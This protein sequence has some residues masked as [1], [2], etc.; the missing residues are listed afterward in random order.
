MFLVCRGLI[1]FR[2]KLELET[3]LEEIRVLREQL[4]AAENDHNR[5]RAICA[6]HAVRID[7]AGPVSNDQDNS[8]LRQVL[9]EI[10][11]NSVLLGDM[12]SNRCDQEMARTRSTDTCLQ[13]E[14]L[15]LQR[16]Q[17]DLAEIVEHI[18]SSNTLREQY[19]SQLTDDFNVLT[20]L[21]LSIDALQREL[22]LEKRS[23]NQKDRKQLPS[24]V[25]PP[26]LS[27]SADR[28]ADLRAQLAALENTY[29]QEH[30]CLQ[31]QLSR[32][33]LNKSSAKSKFQ[34]DIKSLFTDLNF[35]RERLAKT[36]NGLETVNKH[37]T[38]D[39]E[40]L[41][42]IVAPLVDN[43]DGLREKI[44]HLENDIDGYF[45]GHEE[46]QVDD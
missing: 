21:Y 8:E 23:Q 44:N 29:S 35:I 46:S 5:W 28:V 2:L 17:K 42:H 39:E 33:K 20:D 4:S 30:A 22:D 45:Y 10:S 37:Y 13:E 32:T 19:D 6:D 11:R 15:I 26:E 34:S 27:E 3:R 25:Q 41:V 40:E 1:I 31:A 36:E 38:L 7:G 12:M 18:N 16:Q 24:K 9:R 43:I 14:E